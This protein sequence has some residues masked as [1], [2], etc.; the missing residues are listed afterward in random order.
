MARVSQEKIDRVQ[1]QMDRTFGNQPKENK[2]L[3][4]KKQAKE[5]FH[6]TQPLRESFVDEFSNLLSGQFDPSTSPIFRTGKDITEQ[7]FDVAR[8]NVLGSTPRG[9]QLVDVLTG[10][11]ADRASALG[12][13]GADITQDLTNKAFSFATGAPATTIPSLTN[14]AGQQAQA[15]A[16]EKAAKIESFGSLG[17]GAGSF[18]G[19]K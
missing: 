19:A 17:E 9:G 15:E 5:L 10:L 18:F 1:R 11:E 6:M 16:I 12:G 4:A 13:I 14:L 3:G 7:Q 2:R 8:Q